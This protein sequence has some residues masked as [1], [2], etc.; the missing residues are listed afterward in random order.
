MTE[1]TAV[2]TFV[3]K[4][5]NV[6]HTAS[7]EALTVSELEDAASEII[8]RSKRAL[9]QRVVVERVGAGHLA[10]GL[11]MDCSCELDRPPQLHGELHAFKRVDLAL[12]LGVV[13]MPDCFEDLV[14]QSLTTQLN[15]G[16]IRA[17]RVRRYAALQEALAWERAEMREM[18][19]G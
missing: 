13:Y 16:S 4:F 8:G 14:H 2:L 12:P 6:A 19:N 11:A 9:D 1:E 5:G 15:Y 17:G 18:N 3:N 7:T 10:D